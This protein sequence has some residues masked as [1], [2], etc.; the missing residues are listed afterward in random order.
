LVAGWPMGK[1]ASPR[2]TASAIARGTSRPNRP[3]PKT[4][5]IHGA[6]SRKSCLRSTPFSFRGSLIVAKPGFWAA[7]ATV[8]NGPEFPETSNIST[9]PLLVRNCLLD[10]AGP[11]LEFTTYSHSDV[12]TAQTAAS[13]SGA[14]GGRTKRWSFGRAAIA[15]R[16]SSSSE[17][18]SASRLA[19]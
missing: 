5:P 4:P 3:V 8:N 17:M 11:R 10:R 9:S 2:A 14:N 18:P 13:H 19:F 16:S 1:D 15:A 7:L 12:I 6:A